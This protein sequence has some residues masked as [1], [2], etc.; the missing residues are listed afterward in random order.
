MCRKDKA[1]EKND[2]NKF[3]GIRKIHKKRDRR[4]PSNDLKLQCGTWKTERMAQILE[5]ND[6]VKYSTTSQFPLDY[7]L[8]SV[9]CQSIHLTSDTRVHQRTLIDRE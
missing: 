4:W 2:R 7:F 8:E 3:K 1:G 6:N 5:T 9:H